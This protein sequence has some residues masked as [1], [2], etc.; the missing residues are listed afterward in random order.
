[1]SS[2]REAPEI[3]KDPVADSTDVYAFGHPLYNLG[4]TQFPM[5]RAFVYA[6][7]PSLLSSMK[8]AATGDTIGTFR[9]DRATA[10]VG[11]L[12]RGPDLLPI[13]IALDTERGL[14]KTF[15]FQVVNDQLLTP[16]LSYLTI[17]NTLASY[18][19]EFGVA[20][21]GVTGA[22]RVRA[23]GTVAFD[24]VFAGESPAMAAAT[25]VV[26]PIAAL[27]GNDIEQAD[28]DGVDLHITTSERPQTTTLERIWLDAVKIR[29]GTT[30]SLKLLTRT[31]RGE[32]VT[33]TVPIDI[34]PNAA[35]SMS[36]VV[37]DGGTLAQ[38]EQREVRSAPPKSLEQMVRAL[39]RARRTNRLYIRLLRPDAGAVINGERL[40]A[41]PP[42]VLA[43]LE[44]DRNG[45]G[46]APLRNA[47]AG[48][49][50]VVTDSAVS[51][52]KTLTITIQSH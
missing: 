40:S 6:L 29:P 7:L 26:A 23:H 5:T 11:T 46:F 43:V 49:W 30:V 48:E 42:S 31:Y 32:A 18:E 1:M 44:S 35:G 50:E 36:I 51:G 21:F 27:L 14:H 39:N 9:Q 37:S 16:L 19:R 13:R 34:P 22:A 25:S 41:L 24:D 28:L 45:G 3:S 2:H 38:A 52:S 17:L 10:L 12:G 4:T 47:T 8:I 15:S 20:T 33:R